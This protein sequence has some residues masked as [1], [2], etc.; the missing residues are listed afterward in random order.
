[1]VYHVRS[2]RAR[3]RG[4][5]G[6]R[7]SPGPRVVQSPPS[8]V[9]SP[10]MGATD[11]SSCQASQLTPWDSELRL[12][13]R[14]VQFPDRMSRKK[15]FCYPVV[16][17]VSFSTMRDIPSFWDHALQAIAQPGTFPPE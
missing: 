8:T 16:G 17:R 3:P 6:L 13:P 15:P 9:F 12:N 11:N 4:A 14:K 1:M 5:R 2:A 10:V 7:A